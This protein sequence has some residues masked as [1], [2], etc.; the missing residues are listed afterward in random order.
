MDMDP[1]S[2][3]STAAM[4]PR[5]LRDFVDEM[6]V[7]RFLLNNQVAA[8]IADDLQDHNVQTIEVEVWRRTVNGVTQSYPA[9]IFTLDNLDKLLEVNEDARQAFQQRLTEHEGANNPTTTNSVNGT[10]QATPGSSQAEPKA[11]KK[12]KRQEEKEAE[13]AQGRKERIWAT[14]EAPTASR[15]DASIEAELLGTTFRSEEEVRREDAKAG[16]KDQ[17]VPPPTKTFHLVNSE[18]ALTST[19]PSATDDR[20]IEQQKNGMRRSRE[21][22]IDKRQEEEAKAEAARKERV[23]NKAES[24]PD[25][26]MTDRPEEAPPDQI[27]TPGSQALTI[28]ASIRP[29]I[30]KLPEIRAYK[31]ELRI[32]SEKKLQ[33]RIDRLESY[34]AAN[35]TSFNVEEHPKIKAYKEQLRK[36]VE[37][38]LETEIDR[39]RPQQAPASI[40]ATSV[41]MDGL[42][43]VEAYKK[44]VRKEADDVLVK[45]I[46]T[47]NVRNALS[48]ALESGELPW[49]QAYKNKLEEEAKKSLQKHIDALNTKFAQSN[50]AKSGD[51]NQ[52]PWVKEYKTQLKESYTGHLEKRFT[53]ASGGATTFSNIEDHTEVKALKKHLQIQF[54]DSRE[55]LR[56]ETIE[57]LQKHLSGMDQKADA[58]KSQQHSAFD[59]LIQNN[60]KMVKIFFNP[61]CGEMKLTKSAVTKLYSEDNIVRRNFQQDAANPLREYRRELKNQ[62]EKHLADIEREC[63][64]VIK[65][66]FDEKKQV[67]LEVTVSQVIER[68]KQNEPQAPRA[69]TL[70]SGQHLTEDIFRAEKQQITQNFNIYWNQMDEATKH[71]TKGLSQPLTFENLDPVYPRKQE[72]NQRSTSQADSALFKPDEVYVHTSLNRVTKPTPQYISEKLRDADAARFSGQELNLPSDPS[73][74][75][76]ESPPSSEKQPVQ[77]NDPERQSTNQKPTSETP[78]WL[79]PEVRKAGHNHGREISSISMRFDQ[80]TPVIPDDIASNAPPIAPPLRPKPVTDDISYLKSILNGNKKVP[81]VVPT[82]TSARNWYTEYVPLKTAAPISFSAGFANKAGLNRLGEAESM[83]VD[84]PDGGA[85]SRIPMEFDHDGAIG[86]ETTGFHGSEAMIIEDQTNGVKLA[87]VRSM[88][89]NATTTEVNTV[90]APTQHRGERRAP[91]VI[92]PEAATPRLHVADAPRGRSLVREPEDSSTRSTNPQVAQLSLSSAKH[93]DQSPQLHG[94]N[95]GQRHDSRTE[96][97]REN[98]MYASGRKLS[99][100][101]YEAQVKKKILP[102]KGQERPSKLYVQDQEASMH[103]TPRNNADR[104]LFSV[105]LESIDDFHPTELSKLSDRPGCAGDGDDKGGVSE[106]SGPSKDQLHGKK[107]MT[108]KNGLIVPF[109]L[110]STARAMEKKGE[111]V[112]AADLLPILRRPR[113]RAKYI[114]CAELLKAL[115]AENQSVDLSCLPSEEELD[116]LRKEVADFLHSKLKSKF[117]SQKDGFVL[118]V[119]EEVV[120]V[121]GSLAQN[122]EQQFRPEVK[123]EEQKRLPFTNAL[124]NDL[125]AAKPLCI[126][127]P[128]L[129]AVKAKLPTQSQEQEQP[130]KEQGSRAVTP[131]QE[132]LKRMQGSGGPIDA[133]ELNLPHNTQTLRRHEIAPYVQKVAAIRGL[134]ARGT[135]IVNLPQLPSPKEL[136]DM[137]AEVTGK[138]KYKE[139]PPTCNDLEE[140]AKF[141]EMR[142]EQAVL[143]S[144]GVRQ[145]RIK[146]EVE[147]KL[148]DQLVG[149]SISEI[150]GARKRKREVGDNGEPECLARV[151]NGGSGAVESS[152]RFRDVENNHGTASILPIGGPMQARGMLPSAPRVSSGAAAMAERFQSLA[153]SISTDEGRA[154]AIPFYN[155]RNVLR[156]ARLP[157]GEI[158]SYG[159]GVGESEGA[160]V[161]VNEEPMVVQEGRGGNGGNANIVEEESGNDRAQETTRFGVAEGENVV[162]EYV[163]ETEERAGDYLGGGVSRD[164]PVEDGAGTN[165]PYGVGEDGTGH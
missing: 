106:P 121:S 68:G 75:G 164:D 76:V 153:R 15:K 34:K 115:N 73:Q 64:H 5:Q 104:A 62:C 72:K 70:S 113:H 132:R 123:E 98:P 26:S 74:F 129:G 29:G 83:D 9:M 163:A 58:F 78:H 89:H 158:E 65:Q 54:E 17:G 147:F 1:H 82:L 33:I 95:Q 134:I 60:F 18:K 38:K 50:G 144:A 25:E 77:T 28:T 146:N 7:Q 112:I 37:A 6:E 46:E 101:G 159:S 51:M 154:A 136:S 109:H 150:L 40:P 69:H 45:H 4:E 56:Q 161:G 53:Q 120:G 31:E 160:G 91:A 102:L 131:W 10:Q 116:G 80:P 3:E 12:R 79:N 142:R 87:N 22:A 55:R 125:F 107:P 119:E 86:G 43:E 88:Q 42:P 105:K 157:A 49:V 128:Q 16:R 148:E 111:H 103:T 30:D 8:Q 2:C 145:P 52:L 63:R 139:A 24:V 156:F 127:N 141:V 94:Q 110:W 140:R 96:D 108:L 117:K 39:L 137:L 32:E 81:V 114:E 11:D 35:I 130:T 152:L 133:A 155:E 27:E 151:G 23:R 59:K 44:K 162:E 85:T 47:L 48:N 66:S 100:T 90:V 118:D 143:L 138:R 36:E 13:E 126:T 67:K 149:R 122:H 97:A 41:N 14:L 71:L 19:T 165:F 135:V 57:K 21:I 84:S 61:Q 92:Q 93:Q 124:D 20:P 99:V